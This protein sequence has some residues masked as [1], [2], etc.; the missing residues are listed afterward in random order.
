LSRSLVEEARQAGG[1]ALEAWPWEDARE[2]A[3]KGL[4]ARAQD[5]VVWRFGARE[6]VLQSDTPEDGWP[7]IGAGDDVRVWLA[8]RD[9][10][11]RL[12]PDTVLGFVYDEVFREEAR[13]AI[14]KLA[15]LGCRSAL[16]SGDQI[17][18]VYAAA[19]ELSA[20]AHAGQ[21]ADV[22]VAR[23]QATPEDKLQ[24]IAQA[25]SEGLRVAVVGDGINDAPVL[26]KADVSIALDQGAALAQSQADLIVLG[27]RLM[28]VPLAVQ[29]ARQAMRIVKQNLA[30][31]ALYNA[32][33][34][35]LALVGWLP[36][37]LAGLG[38]AISSLG[39]VLNAL[40]LGAFRK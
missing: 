22:Q 25:Q 14:R 5:G 35:P 4:E 9:A 34:I 2:H 32:A 27:G 28:G 20:S 36:P 10:H 7:H 15:E 16:L 29:T 39:V 31:A 33:C 21:A 19:A 1:W 12:L 8:A 6:W 13:P 40:R 3:G 26:A 23:A 38:M 11:N 24:V 30:W 17:S 18:R 37:W